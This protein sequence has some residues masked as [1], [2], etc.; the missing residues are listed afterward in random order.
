MLDGIDVHDGQGDVAWQKV[1]QTNQFAFIRA[2]YGDRFD[3]RYE[4]NYEGCKAN[5][6]PVGLYH[7]FRVTRDPQK[8]ADV[9]CT[10]L[11]T[12]GFGSGDI[13]PVLDVEDNPRYDG[14]WN[15]V[16]NDKYIDGLRLWLASVV[17]SFPKCS[18]IIYTRADFWRTLGNPPGFDKYPLWVAHY[19]SNPQP[20]LP[21]GWSEY[22]F[23][24]YSSN[25]RATGV[26]G[27][28]DLNRFLGNEAALQNILVR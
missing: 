1:A 22:A 17:G 12:V 25:G 7:F 11:K 5:R 19:T 27:G 8:Q 14:P 2:A 4:D 21:E 6:L 23:W 20:S 3:G 16:N 10:A 18:P 28:C 24:Q 15:V 13:S 9:M 26:N